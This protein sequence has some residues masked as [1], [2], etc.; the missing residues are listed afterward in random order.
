MKFFSR[1]L[2]VIA[3]D[4]TAA[5]G[6]GTL[7]RRLAAELGMAYLDTGALYRYVAV[8]AMQQ[9]IDW[10]NEDAVT[11]LAQRLAKTVRPSHLADPAIRS[12]EAGRGA[13]IVSAW[14][15]V[16]QAL[17]DLQQRFAR[18]PPALPGGTL[19]AGAVLDGR[20]IGTVIAP[21]AP[22]KLFV[23]ARLDVRARRR[24]KELQAGGST[25]AYESVLEDMAA[26]DRR[27]AQR[28][29]APMKPAPDA[30]I[31]DTSDMTVEAVLDF[32]RSCVRDRI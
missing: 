2:P 24:W 27:D 25:A 1:K 12:A 20:D 22:V 9:N 11:A 15:G 4:G 28:D 30:I 7:A 3:I 21:D 19:A 10:R 6:K 8:R 31:V 13:S 16:R 32:A 18:K 5:S 17:F 26:R 14:P 29:N 23:T